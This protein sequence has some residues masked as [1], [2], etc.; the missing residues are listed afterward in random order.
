MIEIDH[1]NLKSALSSSTLREIASGIISR[2]VQ[3]NT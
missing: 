2:E 3:R 1:A